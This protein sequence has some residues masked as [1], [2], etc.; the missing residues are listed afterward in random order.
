MAL[1]VILH[2]NFGDKQ[3]SQRRDKPSPKNSYRDLSKSMHGN[4]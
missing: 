2:M 1:S 4:G 3:I